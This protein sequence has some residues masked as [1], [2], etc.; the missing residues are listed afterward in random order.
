[1][2]LWRTIK[3]SGTVK[4]GDVEQ[5]SMFFLNKID[6]NNHMAPILQTWI[7]TA[8]LFQMR[9]QLVHFACVS[10]KQTQS[11]LFKVAPSVWGDFEQQAFLHVE[12]TYSNFSCQNSNN[13]WHRQIKHVSVY[14]W[15]CWEKVTFDQSFVSKH[16]IFSFEN[17]CLGK[18][19][20]SKV[21]GT[22]QKFWGWGAETFRVQSKT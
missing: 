5:F 20:R 17:C 21:V 19:T 22:F 13:L 4:W 2:T 15:A 8:S 10:V 1:M 7:T 16:Q 3:N 18:K 11:K 9:K 12:K 6:Y 14:P